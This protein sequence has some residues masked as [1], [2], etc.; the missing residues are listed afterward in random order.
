MAPAGDVQNGRGQRSRRWPSVKR[1][2]CTVAPPAPP[3]PGR[4]SVL[5]PVTV[6]LPPMASVPATPPPERATMLSTWPLPRSRPPW[7]RTELAVNWPL[8][9]SEPP[10][11]V[12]APLV[13]VRAG[14]G[15]LAAANGQRQQ[16]PSSCNVPP[17]T[18][19]PA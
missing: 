3:C 6:R 4:T 12:V 14:K 2:P 13:G 17:K 15:Q 7:T 10:L 5:L 11:I 8:T 9:A 16:A 18:V 1:P 19:E